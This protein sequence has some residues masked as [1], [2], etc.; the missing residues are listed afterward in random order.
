MNDAIGIIEMFGFVTA[1]TAADAAAKAADVKVIAID[2]NKPANADSVEVPLIMA[3]KVQ[4]S[5]SAVTA[6]VDAAARTAESISGLI[7]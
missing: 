1:I 7:N 5:V 3:V 6:A 2:S 4:G